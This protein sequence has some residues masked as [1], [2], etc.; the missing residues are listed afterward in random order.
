[1]VIKHIRQLLLGFMIGAALLASLELGASAH[2][3]HPILVAQRTQTVQKAGVQKTKVLPG[4]SQHAQA[5]LN[6]LLQRNGLPQNLVQRIAVVQSNTLN[7]ATNGES[8]TFTSALWNKLKTDDQ[9][10]FVIS[11][12][13]AHIDLNHV[14]KTQVR[15][16]GIIGAG[17]L[18]NRLMGSDGSQKSKLLTTT[19]QAGLALTDLKFSRNAEYQ[20]DERGMQLLARAGYAPQAAIETLEILGANNS[21]NTPQFLSSHPKSRSRIEALVRQYR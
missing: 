17:Y 8:I 18:L 10:A 20:A 1:M 3:H 16:I 12:E 7:A 5:I 2:D 6:R 13:M 15:R 11:H 14:Q 9:K 21:A 4:N 19:T